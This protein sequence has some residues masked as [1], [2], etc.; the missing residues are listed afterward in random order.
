MKK[1]LLITVLF[2]MVSFNSFAQEKE[3]KVV[4][5]SG[6][7]VAKTRGENP[8]IKTDF[9]CDAPDVE[10]PK[11]P[12]TRGSVC[13]INFDN[14]TGYDIKVYVDGDFKGWVSPWDEGAVTVYSGYTTVYCITAGGSYEWSAK[15]DC[16]SYFNY[17]LRKENSR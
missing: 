16:D 7:E 17:E 12:A 6:T 2:L 13:T 15:G 1:L 11:P 4:K 8:N 10:A 9:V 3:T 5:I 14:Y